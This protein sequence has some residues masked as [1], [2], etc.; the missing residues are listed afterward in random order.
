MGPSIRHYIAAVNDERVGHGGRQW[1]AFSLSRRAEFAWLAV[2]AVATIVVT[3]FSVFSVHVGRGVVTVGWRQ[4]DRYQAT[5]VLAVTHPFAQISPPASDAERLAATAG[6]YSRIATSTAVLN[7]VLKS[8]PL[9]GSYVA[10]HAVQ[11]AHPAVKP[12]TRAAFEQR[13]TTLLP[14]FSIIGTAGSARQAVT[15]ATRVSK[16]LI[17]YVLNAERQSTGPA[18]MFVSIVR[19]VRATPRQVQGHDLTTPLL[20]F[21][22]LLTLLAVAATCVE[23]KPKPGN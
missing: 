1:L 10:S 9:Q 3:F 21:A 13:Q 4:P 11:Q 19:V 16:T 23:R 8:G 17:D 14:L 18:E 2:A 20:I 15:V 12:N 22:A 5:E 6:L 7:L